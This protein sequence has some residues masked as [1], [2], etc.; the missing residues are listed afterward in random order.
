M[1]FTGQTIKADEALRIGLVNEIYPQNEL[2]ENAKK[3]ADNIGKNIVHAVKNSKNAINDG[4][5]VNID[6][7]IE[8][9]ER[10]FGDCFENKEQQEA[11]N[12]FLHKGKTKNKNKEQNIY[13]LVC[14]S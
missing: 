3:I 14:A 1:I 6:K 9:E 11:M 8:I 12:N 2:M 13:K 4:L 7:A 5:Q 10:L